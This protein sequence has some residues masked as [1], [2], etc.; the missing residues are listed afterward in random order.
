VQGEKRVE[1]NDRQAV[2][3]TSES[4]YAIGGGVVC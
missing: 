3:S 1:D 4:N 2:I